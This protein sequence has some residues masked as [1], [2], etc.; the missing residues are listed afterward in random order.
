MSLLPQLMHY[1][2]RIRADAN[3]YC[4]PACRKL[5]I[6]QCDIQ[7]FTKGFSEG[8]VTDFTALM[9]LKCLIHME[10]TLKRCQWHAAKVTPDT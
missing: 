5:F 4:L 9:L 2:Q 6:A 1:R 10:V 3:E 7:L 8:F